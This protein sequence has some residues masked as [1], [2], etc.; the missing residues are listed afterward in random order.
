MVAVAAA[1]VAVAAAVVAVA[2]AV[3]VAD[4]TVVTVLVADAAA[5]TVLVAEDPTVFVG[6]TEPFVGEEVTVFTGTKVSVATGAATVFVA[7][8]AA[9]L[10]LLVGATGASVAVAGILIIIAV[11]V[12]T[13]CSV[14][15]ISVGTWAVIVAIWAVATSVAKRCSPVILSPHATSDK[16][17]AVMVITLMKVRTILLHVVNRNTLTILC[18]SGFCQCNML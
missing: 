15:A 4:A 13:A 12:N 14:A 18:N 6:T 10:G 9:G 5:V 16:A 2:T 11:C 8:G 3:K 7:A 17:S 1:V